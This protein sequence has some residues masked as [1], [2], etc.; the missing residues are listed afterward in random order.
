M[1]WEKIPLYIVDK[2]V[3]KEQLDDLAR[4]DV[5]VRLVRSRQKGGKEVLYW[6]KLVSD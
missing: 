4:M 3:I 5:P 1:H 6:Q 2:S